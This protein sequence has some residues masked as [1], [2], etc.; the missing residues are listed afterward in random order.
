MKT[1]TTAVMA[2]WAEVSDANAATVTRST[3]LRE[4]EELDSLDLAEFFMSVEEEFDVV[5]PDRV[6]IGLSTIGEVIDRV[7]V[8]LK[9]RPA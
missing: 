9:A 1:T 4:S 8:E 5:L 2:L 3:P 6:C 7:D